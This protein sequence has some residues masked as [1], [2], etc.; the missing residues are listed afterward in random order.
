MRLAL[1]IALVSVTGAGCSG[2]RPSA[3]R[4]PPPQRIGER[5]NATAVSVSPATIAP[6]TGRIA[7]VNPDGAFVILSYPLGKV[8][9]VGRRL[10]VYRNGMK[11]GELKVSEP[12]YQ[13]HTAADIMAGEARAGDEARDN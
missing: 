1:L 13:Q 9:P 3:P 12:Q 5:T 8:P 4:T 6:A 7:R 10:S 2:S 11:V